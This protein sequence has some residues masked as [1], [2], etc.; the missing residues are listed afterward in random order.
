MKKRIFSILLSL[1]LVF[2]MAPMMASALIYDPNPYDAY[3]GIWFGGRYITEERAEDITEAINASA[4]AGEAT[5][6]AFFENTTNTLTFKD[7][8]YVGTDDEYGALT[9]KG[10]FSGEAADPNLYIVFEGENII[11]NTDGLGLY[12]DMSSSTGGNAYVKAAS[13]GSSLTFMGTSKAADTLT[14]V[15]NIAV[16]EGKITIDGDEYPYITFT[17]MPPA[18]KPAEKPAATSVDGGMDMIYADGKEIEGFDRLVFNYTLDVPYEQ[19]SVTFTG[20]MSHPGAWADNLWQ[21]PLKI[22]ANPVV[23]KTTAEDGKTNWFYTITVNRA[24]EVVAEPDPT[25]APT[26]EP[27]VEP[28]ATPAPTAQPTQEPATAPT[29]TP[30]PTSAPQQASFPW[31]IVAAAAVALAVAG[32]VAKKKHSE[33]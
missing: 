3:N 2:S 10:D 14:P 13:V 9:V 12:K 33:E 16:T 7:F 25:P 30:A 17:G 19:T 1:C 28:T 4:G 32:L 22:G 8:K 29:A 18:E 5:G 6:V 26:A 27:T 15:G 11:R 24:P 31:W 20:K 21:I 23:I